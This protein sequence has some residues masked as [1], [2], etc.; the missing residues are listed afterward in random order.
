MRHV[1][2]FSGWLSPSLTIWNLRVVVQVCC[3]DNRGVTQYWVRRGSGECMWHHCIV[4]LCLTKGIKNNVNWNLWSWFQQKEDL[5]DPW[6]AD[7]YEFR[8]SD[9]PITEHELIKCGLRLFFEIN[10]VEKFKVP[11]EV[12]WCLM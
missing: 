5:P 2:S 1:E 3:E 8:F 9:L 11:V 10:V 4:I 12:R 6:T 7:L